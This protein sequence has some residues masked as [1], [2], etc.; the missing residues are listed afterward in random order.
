[1]KKMSHVTANNYV[2]QKGNC[3]APSDGDCF[4]QAVNSA[5]SAR[6]HLHLGSLVCFTSPILYALP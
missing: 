4:V 6:T 1:M 2:L 3:L 5:G